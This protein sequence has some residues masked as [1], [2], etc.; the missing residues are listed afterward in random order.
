MP[1]LEQRRKVGRHAGGPG[2]GRF[3]RHGAEQAV[4]SLFAGMHRLAAIGV[5]NLGEIHSPG[6]IGVDQQLAAPVIPRL[7][8]K[9]R[10]DAF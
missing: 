9:P 8:D 7:V 10:R 2:A 6:H 4:V 1:A 3:A 5:G